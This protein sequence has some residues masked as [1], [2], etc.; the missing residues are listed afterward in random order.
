MHFT[1][2]DLT[3]KFTRLEF[4]NKLHIVAGSIT[5]VADDQ[6]DAG[7]VRARLRG[8]GQETYRLFCERSRLSD[9]PTS[10][11]CTTTNHHSALLHLASLCTTYRD[12]TVIGYIG[13]RVGVILPP[14][15][16]R[17]IIPNSLPR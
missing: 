7:A 6:P 16:L 14:G 11:E 8:D 13:E 15:H 2:N 1:I 17:Q 4:V 9:E 5:V 12:H 10:H 3:L